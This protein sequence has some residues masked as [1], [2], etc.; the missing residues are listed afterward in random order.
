[1]HLN[2]LNLAVPDVS[3]ACSFFETF[4]E[5]HCVDTKG[6]DTLT[7]LKG[8]DDFTLVLSNLDKSATPV[9][10]KDFHIGF[11]LD[12]P[13]QVHEVFHKLQSAGIQLPHPPREMRSGFTFYCYALGSILLEVSCPLK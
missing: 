8:K 11:I 12:T 6:A 1:M 5:F 7:V 3:Q 2:H 9:Y 10:P 4:F 13:E